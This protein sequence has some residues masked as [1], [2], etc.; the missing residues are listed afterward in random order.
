MQGPRGGDIALALMLFRAGNADQ[1]AQACRAILRENG[2][3]AAALYLLALTAMQRQDCAEAERIFAKVTKIEPNSAEIWANRG[4]N[5]IAMGKPDRALDTFERALAIEPMYL[6]ALYNRAK[7]LTDA[8]R[9]EEA[10]ASYDRCLAVMPQFAD[11][12]H[13]RGTVLTNLRRY[14]E[15][16]ASFDKC[17]AI[18]PEAPDTL[19][20][21]GNLL[22]SL[23][24]LDE[25]LASFDRCISA[26]PAFAPA[27]LDTGML[28][29][30]MKR[31]EEAAKVFARA[32]ELD[33]RIRYALG[34]LIQTR[35]RICDWSDWH[36]LKSRLLGCVQKNELAT[37][38]G[39]LFAVTD[40]PADQLRCAQA[41]IAAEF[42]SADPA[43]WP[44]E[45][46]AHDRIR[47]AYLSANFLDHA[48]S[49]LI[50]GLFE[51]HDRSA[52]EITAVSFVAD[53]ADAVQ[54]RIRRACDRYI[55]V[56]GRSDGEVA[57][58]LR[59]L[60]VDIAVDL[61][62][63]TLDSR[64]AIFALRPAPVQVNYLGY[65]GTMGAPCM[66][67]V[68]ADPRVLPLSEASCWTEK[69]VHLPDSFMVTDGTAKVAETTPTRA[70]VGLPSDGFVFCAFNQH[71]KITPE[72]F[73]IWMRLLQRVD[74]SVLWLANGLQATVRNLRQEAERRGVAADRLVFA[75]HVARHED[76]LARHRLADLFLDT[77]PY[78]A[79]TTACDA[80]W[81]G[82]PVLTCRGSTFAGRVAASLLHAIGLDELVTA[83]AAEYEALAV[84]I[85]TTPALLVALK[86]KLAAH[87]GSHALFD[88][89]R[90]RRNIE[91]A[92]ITMHERRLRG[93]RAAHFAVQVTGAALEAAQQ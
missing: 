93:E 31:Y 32:L 91:A 39:V 4:N 18:T 90:F 75:E 49:R 74:G 84:K 68:I 41:Y 54:A 5:L 85:A 11:A 40:S 10:L 28:L 55:D 77:L 34:N 46:H 89:D 25:A 24:R 72:V 9:L 44:P 22:A 52:F 20:I 67:Y 29:V 51:C 30:R 66:D 3:D 21:R 43:L 76:H 27:W 6:E 82:V 13:N 38:P 1:A 42:P 62:G 61:M 36:A 69:I 80:L 70:E 17:L 71:F 45:R 65:A 81:T 73:D 92:F 56:S 33:P 88:T 83:S 15:A 50:A 7:L 37:P 63:F 35:W 79:H 59:D 87:R 47:V 26:A 86:E 57:Q 78:N 23:G 19:C 53:S 64:P 12:L 14:E 16:L 48:V 60:E 8:G 58:V 2:K